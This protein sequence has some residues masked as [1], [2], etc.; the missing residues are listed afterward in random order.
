MT[1]SNSSS[2]STDGRTHDGTWD[3]GAGAVDNSEPD[4]TSSGTSV[5]VGPRRWLPV[6]AVAVIA[7]LLAGAWLVIRGGGDSPPA[8]RAVEGDA[9]RVPPAHA[10][11]VDFPEGTTFTDG[12]ERLKNIGDE[13]ISLSH[14]ELL[15]DEVPF[16]IVGAMYAGDARKIGALQLSEGFPPDRP[17]LLGPLEPLDGAVIEPGDDLGIELLLGLRVSR[18][19]YGE[20]TGVRVFYEAGGKDYYVDMPAGLVLCPPGGDTHKCLSRYEDEHYPG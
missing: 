5:D 20:R 17:K 16:E 10:W 2:D 1:T 7:A 11:V 14:V 8:G 15:G 12:F 13:P 18:E 19:G 9:L 6:V 4:E 3:V